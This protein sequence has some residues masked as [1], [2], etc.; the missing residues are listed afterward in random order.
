MEWDAE[1]WDQNI[2][3]S[4]QVMLVEHNPLEW[5]RELGKLKVPKLERKISQEILAFLKETGIRNAD[6]QLYF[7]LTTE[8]MRGDYSSLSH[9]PDL[10][11]KAQGISPSNFLFEIIG[12]MGDFGCWR[13]SYTTPLSW[14]F[15]HHLLKEIFGD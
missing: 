5:D 15:V 13:G 14:I 7:D 4:C 1:K 12:H 6:L 9:D 8:F 11:E 2:H 3:L 10:L